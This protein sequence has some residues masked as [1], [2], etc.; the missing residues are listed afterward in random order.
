MLAGKKESKKNS[1]RDAV[2]MHHHEP[3]ALIGPK[4]S[5]IAFTSFLK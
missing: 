1:S 4:Q 5:I 2:G 3:A